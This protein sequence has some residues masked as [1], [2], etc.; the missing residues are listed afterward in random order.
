MTSNPIAGGEAAVTS[1]P[2]PGG[3]TAVTSTP[4]PGG[5]TAVTSRVSAEI[6]VLQSQLAKLRHDHTVLVTMQQALGL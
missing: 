6:E 4:M 2:M 3:K 1:T 5:K